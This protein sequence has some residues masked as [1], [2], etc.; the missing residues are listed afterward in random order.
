MRSKIQYCEN[1]LPRVSRTF[2]PTIRRLPKGLRLPV[3]VAYLL[4][5][6]ADTI[7]D[8][9]DLSIEQKKEMLSHYAN[10]FT[11]ENTAAYHQLLALLKFLPQHSADEQLA[12]KLPVVMEVFYSFSPNVRGLIARWVAEMS[13]G[14]RKYAQAKQKRRFSFL[15]SMKE[16]DEYTYYVAGTVGYLLTELFSYYSKKITPMVKMRLEQLAESF[17]KGLQLVNIIRD[18]AA[19]LK[20]GQSYIPDELL[21]KYHLTRESI[22]QKEN[23]DRAVQLFN[24]LIR[25]AVHHLDRALDYTLTIPKE[26]TR[27]RLFCIL[28]LFWALR[29]LELIQRNTL[30]LLDSEKIKI[31]R[32]A[33]RKEFLLALI[34]VNSNRM[35]R[36]YYQRIRSSIDRPLLNTQ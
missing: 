15:K 13:L 35:L 16:L 12:H 7:E 11:G 2:A 28:P 31:S 4:C 25:N 5:R 30:A 33:V 19:D 29:T 27:I 36:W 6:I 9:P 23:A 10:I 20:R 24:E 22:F 21:Q 17:G 18:A 34:H 3:T 14:M 32:R 1:M 8:S 26:E